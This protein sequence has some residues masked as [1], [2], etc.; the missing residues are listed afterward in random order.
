[1]KEV[2][3]RTVLEFFNCRSVQHW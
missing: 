1:M 3:L 2:G